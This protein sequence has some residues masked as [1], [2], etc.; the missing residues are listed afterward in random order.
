MP[1]VV[2]GILKVSETNTQ[3]LK[4]L[5]EKLFVSVTVSRVSGSVYSYPISKPSTSGVSGYT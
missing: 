5:L 2:S 3:R 1:S 4:M